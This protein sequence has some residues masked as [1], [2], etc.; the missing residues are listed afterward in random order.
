VRPGGSLVAAVWVPADERDR[1]AYASVLGCEPAGPF[2]LSD[3]G[4]L[5]GLFTRVG[6]HP[7]E[8]TVVSCPWRY[9]DEETAL[10]GLLSA[11]PAGAGGPLDSTGWYESL[12]K[13]RDVV[14]PYR[15]DDGSY[16]LHAAVKIVIARV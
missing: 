16:L 12:T 11:G 1:A 13:V 15:R 3:P 5:E 4:V 7:A 2:G 9:R 10:R 8:P 14:A 6:L